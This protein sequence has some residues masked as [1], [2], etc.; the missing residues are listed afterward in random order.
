MSDETT[1]PQ[2]QIKFSW[3]LGVFAA[4]VLFVV[5][6]AYSSRMTQ[7]Y[8]DYDETRAQARYETL[9]TVRK[10]E[11]K[12]I[13][14]VDDKGKPT[15]EWVDQSKGLIRIPIEEAMAREVEALKAQ[16]PQAGCAI[17]QPPPASA[18]APAAGGST[19][20]PPAATP[21]PKK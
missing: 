15:A 13:H 19:N 2:P 18:P 14:P 6:G 21:P 10:A 5:I 1:L 7:T 8:T 16:A 17:A 9:A 4:L 11:D 3:L 20:A 12:L